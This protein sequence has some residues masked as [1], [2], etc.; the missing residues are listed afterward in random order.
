MICDDS[1]GGFVWLMQK[2]SK[3]KQKEKVTDAVLFEI[4]SR[5]R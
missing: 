1:D 5:L 2:W 3:R 4:A